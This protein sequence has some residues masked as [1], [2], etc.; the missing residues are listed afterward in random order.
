MNNKG[1]EKQ[2]KKRNR[3]DHNMDLTICNIVEDTDRIRGQIDWNSI[4]EKYKLH[5]SQDLSLSQLRTLHQAARNRLNSRPGSCIERNNKHKSNTTITIIG[6]S[7]SSSS[8][9]NG[10]SGSGYS[11]DNNDHGND[12]NSSDNDN[13]NDKSNDNDNSS[14]TDSSNDNDNSNANINTDTSGSI[15]GNTNGSRKALTEPPVNNNHF[16]Q[17]ENVLLLD[18]VKK[19][20]IDRN[21]K[22]KWDQLAGLYHRAA[23]DL[24]NTNINK[25]LYKRPKDKL[26]QRYKDIMKKR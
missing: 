17:D 3:Y 18:L 4:M 13:G 15:N 11:N 6:N 1:K 14:D 7:N 26:L 12:D 20:Y 25:V 10:I 21:M 9:S 2:P 19:N 22:V 5:S 23:L 24:I 8:N 16:T